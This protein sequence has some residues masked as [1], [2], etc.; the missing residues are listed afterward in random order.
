M[1]RGSW[2]AIYADEGLGMVDIE[3][4]GGGGECMLGLCK[5]LCG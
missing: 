1:D 2:L 5:M 3:S 4:H